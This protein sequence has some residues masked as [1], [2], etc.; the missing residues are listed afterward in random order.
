MIVGTLVAGL[1]SRVGPVILGLAGS[2]KLFP[3]ILVAGYLAERR[4]LAASVA[5][6]VTSVLWL[7]ILAFDFLLYRQIGGPSFYVGGVSLFGVSPLLW[8]PVAIAAAGVP[9]GLCG[10][11]L[12]VDLARGRGSHPVGRAAS[13]AFLTRPTFCSAS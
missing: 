11:R 3:L 7:N 5:I 9:I 8:L 2:L 1:R 4:W 6:G 12:T 10:A 13:L